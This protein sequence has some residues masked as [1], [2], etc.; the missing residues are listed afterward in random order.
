MSEREGR[1]RRRGSVVHRGAG[2]WLLRVTVGTDENRRQVRKNKVVRGT[3]VEAERQLT[4]L[5]RKLDGGESLPISKQTLGAWLEEWLSSWCNDVAPQT[6]SDYRR[7][8]ALYVSRDLR[9]V[10]LTTLSPRQIQDFINELP[11]RGSRGAPL[12]P[13]TV[14]YVHAILRAALTRALKLGKVSRNVASLVDLPKQ[15]RREMKAFSPVQAGRFLAAA[16]D[17]RWYALWLLLVSTGLR[18]SEALGLMWADVEESTLRVQRTLVRDRGGE[19]RLAEPKTAR[20][21]RAIAIHEDVTRALRELRRRQLTERFRLGPA[22]EDHDLVFATEV[23]TPLHLRNLEAR[24]FKAI[25]RTAELP[26]VRLY[27]LRHTAASLMLANGENLKVVADRLGHASIKLTADV[28]SH[29]TPEVDRQAADR[30]AELL[31]Q[32]RIAVASES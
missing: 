18:P 25:L 8:L 3:K 28:Y 23:G 15:P 4:A 1:G 27:D 32:S 16:Q 11:S 6:R 29:V 30:L 12:T 17:D 24:H 7:K 26:P 14:R 31:R 10:P 2:K 21:R 22:Y 9:V 20:S 5:L 19:W 13:R